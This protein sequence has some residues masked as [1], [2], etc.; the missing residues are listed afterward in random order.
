M[1]IRLVLNLLGRL[2]LVDSALMTPALLIALADQTP[3]A[4]AL[5]ISMALTAAVGILCALV[6]PRSDTL[7]LFR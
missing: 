2:L 1:N 5:G 6:R 4:G 7:R 3:D